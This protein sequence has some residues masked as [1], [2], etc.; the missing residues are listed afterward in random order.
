M[1]D[2][3][4]ALSKILTS[5][6]G[7]EGDTVPWLAGMSDDDLRIVVQTFQPDVAVSLFAAAVTKSIDLGSFELAER[8]IACL[9]TELATAVSGPQLAQVRYLRGELA[10]KR[11]DW[12]A[13]GGYFEESANLVD[14]FTKKS[15]AL[16]NA[17]QATLFLG[18]IARAQS[19]YEGALSFDETESFQQGIVHACLGL[20]KVA[21]ALNDATQAVSWLER[22]EKTDKDKLSG[23]ERGGWL[24]RDSVSP[25]ISGASAG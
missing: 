16:T 4:S 9:E 23:V 19:L 24:R 21:L 20:S 8:L 5:F 15:K 11:N 7:P 12:A 25:S 22:A 3:H 17:A 18:N 2:R 1:A 6:P 14:D 10:L 13:A